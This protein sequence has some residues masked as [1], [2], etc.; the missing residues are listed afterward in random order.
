[1]FT[2]T[3]CKNVHLLDS[4]THE[5]VCGWSNAHVHVLSSENKHKRTY[6]EDFHDSL[7]KEDY[8]VIIMHGE[9]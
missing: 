8:G 2:E 7:L 6:F 9:D 1:M 5:D 3:L 4:G